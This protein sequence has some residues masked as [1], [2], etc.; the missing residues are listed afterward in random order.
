MTLQEYNDLYKQPLL[1]SMTITTSG[2]ITITNANIVSETMSLEKSLCSETNLRYGRCEA[3]CFKIRIADMNHDFTGEWL[4]VVQDVMTDSEGYLL[5]QNGLYLLTEDGYKIKLKDEEIDE[6][7]AVYGRFKAHSDKPSNDRRWRDLTCYDVMYDILNADVI[8]WYNGLTF[9]MTLKNLRDS[10][11]AYLG[12]TQETTTL[13]NDSFV[14]PGGFS[15][16]GS[17][18]GKT[19]IESICELNGVFGQI[20]GDGKFQYVSLSSPPTLTLDYYVDGTGSYEDY[21]TEAVTGINAKGTTDDV[22]T[23]VGT[24]TNLYIIANNPLIY[25]TEGTTALTTALN[26]LL[27][28]ITAIQFRPFKVTTYGNPMLPLGTQITLNTKNQTIVSYVVRKELNGIQSLKDTISATSDK[29]QPTAV[30]SPKTEITRTKGKVHE[31]EVTVDGLTS[32]VTATETNLSNNYSTTTQMN[33]AI[34]QSATDIT[35]QVSNNYVT[36]AAYNAEVQNLQDQIDGRIEYFDGN[37]VPTLNNAPASSWTTTA[38][39]DSHVGDLYRYH[40]TDQGVEKTDYYRFDKDTTTNPPTYSWVTLGESEADEALRQAELANQKADA[41]QA[42]LDDLQEDIEDNYSTTTQMNSAINQK[43][44]EI[45]QTVSTTY[46]T[47][48]DATSKLNTANTNAQGYATQAKNDANASTDSKLTNYYTKTQTDSAITQKANE[49]TLNVSENYTTKTEFGNLEI[50]GTNLI[51]NTHDFKGA[52]INV[53]AGASIKTDEPIPYVHFV[54]TEVTWNNV[55]L[56]PN[57]PIELINGKTVTISVEVRA[58]EAMGSMVGGIAFAIGGYPNTET[59]VRS[60][61]KGKYYNTDV[62]SVGQWVKLTY[63]VDI[64]LND[65]SVDSGHT[66]GEVKFFSLLLYDHAGKSMDFRHPKLEIGNKATA[67]SPAPEDTEEK[68]GSRNYF[69]YFRSDKAAPC[70]GDGNF[71]PWPTSGEYALDDYRNTGSF[72]QFPNLSV[73]MKS[74][75]GKQLRLSFD[76]ISPNGAT[77][78]QVY[79][80]NATPRYSINITTVSPALTTSWQHYSIPLIVTDNGSSGTNENAS[81]KIEFYA[82]DKMGAKIRNVKLEINEVE[83]DWSYAPEDYANNKEAQDYAT[84]AQTNAVNTAKSYTD[85]QLQITS[86]SILSTVEQGYTT[87]TE[88]NNLSI[89]GENLLIETNRGTARWYQTVGSKLKAPTLESITWLGRN[90]LKVTGN[91]VNDSSSS[92]GWHVLFYLPTGGFG[93]NLLANTEYTISFDSTFKHNRFTLQQSDGRNNILIGGYITL[94]AVEK[95]DANGDTYWHHYATCKTRTDLTTITNIRNTTIYFDTVTYF[96]T[97]GSVA[98]YANLKIEEGNRATDWSPSPVEMSSKSEVEQLANKVAVKV[99][100]SGRLVT[101]ELGVNPASSTSYVKVKADDLDIIANGNLQLTAKLIGIT[102]TNFTVTSAGK[103]TCTGANVKGD[104][105]TDTLKIDNKAYLSIETATATYTSFTLSY[106]LSANPYGA[107]SSAVQSNRLLIS[108]GYGLNIPSD[109]YFGKYVKMNDN[110]LVNKDL[111]VNGNFLAVGNACVNG[112][113]RCAGTVYVDQEGSFGAGIELGTKSADSPAIIDFH[114]AST[115]TD[116]TARIW[117]RGENTVD[118]IG[119]NSSTWGIWRAASFNSQSSK[120]VKKNIK[121]VTEKEARNI[122]KLRPVKFDY[123]N[124]D[125][126]NQRGLIAE[127]VLEIMPEM[128]NVPKDYTGFN[129]DEPWNTPSI[130]YSKFVPYLIKMIQILQKEIDDLKK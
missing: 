103:L 55:K 23:I 122:L 112:W 9:P 40:Y 110:A 38:E 36:Q 92:S 119:K 51:R 67:W 98:K 72:T 120:Y 64:N 84:T 113:L 116:Y 130:D 58:N 14:T 105:V 45:N 35:T 127:E 77:A 70:S 24:D 108:S 86:S 12:I 30:N 69:L 28:H 75:L 50:G 96:E 26:T 43:A 18:S 3:A 121:D 27:R 107:L 124:S 57:V 125:L 61:S 48:S 20:T 56:Y 83:T 8:S 62:L 87:K 81:N 114:W 80:R 74:F 109:V 93:Q 91:G 7:R 115:N 41:A 19:V 82:P 100:S 90:A 52:Y 49:I 66:I 102:S 63:T 15:V 44:D 68:I 94:N 22:G 29:H 47:K 31:L 53:P 37:V 126:T 78:F 59:Q 2:G 99:N 71:R 118:L 5:T 25:G 54:E 13:I 128:V 79:N 32:R 33:T 85:A 88:F 65:W 1:K 95:T 89:G 106:D 111:Q 129:K 117:Q 21:V 76:A 4:N 123:K 34:Q 6:A 60:A 42:Q 17:L 101:A 10:F 73:P 16:S 104:I 97:A 11:F 46:E 39:K